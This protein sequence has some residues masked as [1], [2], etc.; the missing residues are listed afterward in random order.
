MAEFDLKDLEKISQSE[1]ILELLV[2]KGIIK[3][4][5]FLKQ[6]AYEKE[7]SHLQKQML[8]LQEYLIH[9]P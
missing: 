6:L 8:R 9:N 7:L 5:K 1:K 4:K 2:E 3:E